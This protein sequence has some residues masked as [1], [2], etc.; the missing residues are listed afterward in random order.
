MKWTPYVMVRITLVFASGILLGHFYPT[1]LAGD[2]CTVF[3]TILCFLYFVVRLVLRRHTSVRIAS[4][5]LGLSFI[6][7]SGYTLVEIRDQ[8][9]NN[10]ALLNFPAAIQGYRVRLTSGAEQR[11]NSWRRTGEVVGVYSAGTWA[12]CSGQLLL[13]WPFDAGADHLEY[14]DELIV[15]GT[16]T[17]VPGPQNP[18]GFDYR[19]Y[20]ARKSIYHQHRIGKN[21]WTLVHRSG[22]LSIIYYAI[23]VRNWTI[24][25]IDELVRGD[26]ERAIV[27]AFTIGVTE[28]IDDELKQAYAAG[29]AMH[30]LAV[31]GMHVS[32][33]YGVLLLLLKPLERRQGGPWTIALVSL[34]VLWMYA[35][36]TGLPPSVLRAVAMFSFVAV[37]KPLGR[38]TAIINTLAA[39]A[40]FLLCYDPNLIL[41]AGFQLS[42]LAVLGIVL[43][44]RP[45]YNLW[46]PRWA[47]LNWTWQITCVSVAAQLATL[48][49]TLYY[50][51]QFPVYFLLANLF[52]IP[53][54][55]II[56]LGGICLLLM[57]PIPFL[58]EWLARALEFFVFL[59]NEGL[60]LIERLPASIVYPI[61]LSLVQAFCMGALLMCIYR[62]LATRKAIWMYAV[63]GVILVFLTNSVI[64][65]GVQ[66]RQFVVY[67][68]SRHTAI[69]W[70][71]GGKSY[72]LLDSAFARDPAGI[73]FHLEPNHLANGVHQADFVEPNY[74]QG[75]NFFVFGSRQILM[76]HSTKFQPLGAFRSH[77]L[78]ISSN[79][80]KSLK[81]LS[82]T[83]TFDYV[84]LD[85]SNS[86]GYA[87]RIREEAA[88]L[89][90]PC[91]SVL[92]DGAFIKYL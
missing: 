54:S 5:L 44:Y 16:P 92:T 72:T 85:S 20:L 89:G 77:Y 52:V 63:F 50:F 19:T 51:H 21:D 68:V 86:S 82:R 69:E 37:A 24:R 30:A 2:W 27:K 55:T 13:Y 64:R 3:L 6:F 35:F 56:L 90:K 41:A 70:L 60:F 61:S 73:K 40:F 46:E 74:D 25:T 34:L 10:D 7:I 22:D 11:Q 1:F 18:H 29:G 31:S 42:Y 9:L 58:A 17:R 62:L 65:S 83:V 57:S 79:A 48:P 45:I 32:I 23:R 59:L 28:G 53:I 75:A 81:T 14:G 91:H 66:D 39:S 49:V 71:G 78:V 88:R 67:K 36:V 4:G 38:T 8:S 80:V 76:I 43:F 87:R 12:S 15:K 33:L 26:R 47:W 84:V